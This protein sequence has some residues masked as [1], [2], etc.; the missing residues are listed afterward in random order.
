MH[1][2]QQGP[3]SPSSG[4]PPGMRVSGGQHMV[5]PSLGQQF[6]EHIEVCNTLPRIALH[7]TTLCMTC[8]ALYALLQA[9]LPW[10]CS[11]SANKLKS[12]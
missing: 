6:F 12:H 2:G 4:P 5:A 8:L 1:M 9:L 10:S 11:Q 7:H 3:P